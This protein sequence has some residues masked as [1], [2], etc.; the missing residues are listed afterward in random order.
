MGTARGAL[1]RFETLEGL[2]GGHCVPSHKAVLNHPAD[3]NRL[4]GR[5]ARDAGSGEAAGRVGTSLRERDPGEGR[6]E[7]E[8]GDGARRDGQPPPASVTHEG[9]CKGGT[10]RD[11]NSRPLPLLVTHAT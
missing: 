3:H 8:A 10:W 11:V 5:I 7:A 9:G 2:T 6:W 4:D 1:A